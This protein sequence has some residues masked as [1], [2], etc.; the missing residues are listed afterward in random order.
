MAPNHRIFICTNSPLASHRSS[1]APIQRRALLNAPCAQK[2]ALPSTA[3]SSGPSFVLDGRPSCQ[4]RALPKRRSR[5]TAR[6]SSSRTRRTTRSRSLKRPTRA[7]M[8]PPKA[9]SPGRS[10]ELDGTPPGNECA[11]PRTFDDTLPRQLHLL[12]HARSLS[13]Q[14]HWRRIG[15]ALP[16][17]HSPDS[18]PLSF[19]LSSMRYTVLRPPRPPWQ[20]ASTGTASSSRQRGRAQRCAVEA[21]KGIRSAVKRR[22]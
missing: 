5:S 10:F 16:A 3:C 20:R 1:A 9:R 19:S 4:R 6:S 8:R 17:P 18:L 14:L 2:L 15:R 11:P 12:N 13:C 22:T 7:T 21:S